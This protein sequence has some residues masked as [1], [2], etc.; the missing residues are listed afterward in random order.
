ML[1]QVH[2]KKKR[3]FSL[4]TSFGQKKKLTSLQSSSENLTNKIKHRVRFWTFQNFTFLLKSDSIA[5]FVE[6]IYIFFGNEIALYKI[7][8]LF[9]KPIWHSVAFNILLQC[10]Y[11]NIISISHKVIMVKNQEKDYLFGTKR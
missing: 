7:I 2:L 11:A 4:F 9:R 8:V 10:R 6:N 1:T 5:F 3:A